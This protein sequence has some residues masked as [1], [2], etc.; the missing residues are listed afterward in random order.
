MKVLFSFFIILV[1]CQVNAQTQGTIMYEEKIDVH[2]RMTGERAQW[3][4]RVPQFRTTHMELVFDDD[5]AVYRKSE[6]A[7]EEAPPPEAGGRGFRFRMRGGG[8]NGVVYLNYL[9]DRRVEQREFL[10]KKF[11][12]RG[13]PERRAWKMTGESMQV[14][15]YLCQKATFQDSTQNIVAWFTPQIAVPLGPAQYAQLPGLVLHVDINEGERTYTAQTIELD[16]V[17]SSLLKEPTKG[18]E[19]THEEFQTLVREKMKEMRGNNPRRPGR[20]GR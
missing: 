12:I 7:T 5:E 13:E 14:G 19:V 6:T 2:R 16:E 20:G 17:D 4:D 18:K 11:L 1:A 10:D 9:E 3:K 8:G 15:Q